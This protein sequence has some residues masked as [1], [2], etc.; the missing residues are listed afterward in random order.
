MAEEWGKWIEHDGRGCPAGVV[1]KLVQ[2]NLAAIR[3]IAESDLRS[4]DH[5]FRV[6]WFAGNLCI[7]E[8]IA[9]NHLAWDHRHFGRHYCGSR[10]AK[11]THYRVRRPDALRQLI[12]LVENLPAPALD[13][14]PRE[15]VPA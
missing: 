11:V 5:G 6:L 3:N 14:V 4:I 1:G 7:V 8:G 13:T 10:I 2:I 15:G 12:D 9:G